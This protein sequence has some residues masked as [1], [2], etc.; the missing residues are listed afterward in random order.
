MN[1]PNMTHIRKP[2]NALEAEVLKNS[3]LYLR[4]DPF[5]ANK[6]LQGMAHPSPLNRYSPFSF[7]S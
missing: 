5:K 7:V 1:T 4:C 2:I 6:P 3:I